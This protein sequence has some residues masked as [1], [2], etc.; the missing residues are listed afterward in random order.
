MV[1]A[2]PTRIRRMPKMTRPADPSMPIS[3]IGNMPTRKI[4]S[5]GSS[6]HVSDRARIGGPIETATKAADSR[7]GFPGQSSRKGV[8]AARKSHGCHLGADFGAQLVDQL[9]AL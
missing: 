6:S 2:R 3:S 8:N 7:P 4:G 1:L 5:N 9:E